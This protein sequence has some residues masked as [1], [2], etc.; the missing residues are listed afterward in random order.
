MLGELTLDYARRAVS[1][2]GRPVSLTPT[3]Y[4]LLYEL[5]VNAGFTLSFDHLMERVWGLKDTGNR[6]N[7][8][9]YVKRLRRKLGEDADSPKYIFPESRVGYRMG[10]PETPADAAEASGRL[11][12]RHE[13]NHEGS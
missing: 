1:V 11:H 7:L 12:L 2:A 9:N 3:E 10:K 6:G 13:P 8:R 4:S 5:S